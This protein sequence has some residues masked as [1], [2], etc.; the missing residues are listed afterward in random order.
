MLV[1]LPCVVQ[2]ISE[3]HETNVLGLGRSEVYGV[4]EAF[5]RLRVVTFHSPIEGGN[6]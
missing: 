6:S 3:A 2:K 1:T 5:H 4:T